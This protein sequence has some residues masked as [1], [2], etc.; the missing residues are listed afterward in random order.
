[1]YNVVKDVTNTS[2]HL[3]ADDIVV[4]HNANT[5]ALGFDDLQPAFDRNKDIFK[6]KIK[7]LLFTQLLSFLY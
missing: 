3:Y 1:M 6:T 7:F 4:Y 5:S 2:L